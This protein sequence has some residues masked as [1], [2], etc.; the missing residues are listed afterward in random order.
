MATVPITSQW[1]TKAT[2]NVYERNISG[3]IIC[4][5]LPN[6][7]LFNFITFVPSPVLLLFLLL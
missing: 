4:L 5:R 7:K 1:Y 6:I 3:V 2:E